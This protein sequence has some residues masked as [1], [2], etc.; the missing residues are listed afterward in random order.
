MSAD[1]KQ[2]LQNYLDIA[3]RRYDS[4]ADQ[5]RLVVNA[6]AVL[7]VLALIFLLLIVPAQ[8][9][10]SDSQLKLAGQQNLLGWM[11][12]NEALA[13]QAAS[14]GGAVT[15]TDQPLQSIITSTAGP[16]GV[17][18]KRYENESETKLRVWLE[19]VPFDKMV[20]WLDQLESRY[21]LVIVNIAIDAEKEP[22]LVT[23]KLVLQN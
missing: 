22:G 12:E 9:S 16:L 19:K 4:L 20:R 15:K 3:Q 11:K 18:V 2:N 1:L 17:A 8:Q 6:V 23:A 5:E 7:I 14:G 21:G 13:R 10:V